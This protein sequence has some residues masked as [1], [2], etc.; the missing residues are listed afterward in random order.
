LAR[1]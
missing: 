1:Q